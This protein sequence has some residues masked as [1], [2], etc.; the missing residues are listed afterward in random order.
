MLIWVSWWID[1]SREVDWLLNMIGCGVLW[2]YCVDVFVSV[3]ASVCV[4]W[5]E[6]R[7]VGKVKGTPLHVRM[8][9]GLFVLLLIWYLVLWV[10]VNWWD[11]CVNL[12]CHEP[13]N[14]MMRH[15]YDEYVQLIM[16]LWWLMIYE[17]CL[18]FGMSVWQILGNLRY[19][20]YAAGFSSKLWT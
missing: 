6:T 1:L 16:M 2:H 3:D 9:S 15:D 14:D 18:W 13:D 12:G 19:S 17:W 11:D 5:L 7:V 4:M 8:P 10:D 20:R